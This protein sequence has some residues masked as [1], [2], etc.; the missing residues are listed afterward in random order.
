[1]QAIQRQTGLAM[2]LG[3]N[4]ALASVMGPDENMT[5]P[6]SNKLTVMICDICDGTGVSLLQIALEAK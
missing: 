6:L 3:G 2:M 5:I 1:M 4:G